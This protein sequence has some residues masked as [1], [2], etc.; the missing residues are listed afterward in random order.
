MPEQFEAL[1]GSPQ[2]EVGLFKGREGSLCN[3][4][5]KKGLIFILRMGVGRVVATKFRLGGRV[6]V[7]QNHL[8]PNSNFSSDF[9][10][11]ISEI[12]ENL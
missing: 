6:Q 5:D 2:T 9:A 8:P 7:S 4:V 11:F 1:E 10:H 12:L 3:K